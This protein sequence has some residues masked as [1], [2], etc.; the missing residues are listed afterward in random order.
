MDEHGAKT[1]REY[2]EYMLRDDTEMAH[3]LEKTPVIYPY[4]DQSLQN[5]PKR[6]GRFAVDLAHRGLVE[7]RGVARSIVTPFFVYKKDG[8]KRRLILDCRRTNLLFR[9]PPKV[10]MAGG[11]KL[12]ELH[13]GP[14][15]KIWMAKSD[16]KDYFYCLRLDS[17]IVE[18]FAMPAIPI[19][20]VKQIYRENGE[21]VP[22]AVL[23]LELLGYEN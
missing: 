19:T 5:S 18:Y 6:F 10:K 23:R 9:D 7:W 12:G 15:Q 20:L 22:G 4:M 1:L 17:D 14:Q 13:L 8:V 3:I 21:E 2:S 16:I 11:A